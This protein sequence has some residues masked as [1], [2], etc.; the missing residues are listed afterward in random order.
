DHPNIARVLDAGAMDNG[1]PFFVMDLVLGLP[2]TDYCDKRKLGVEDRLELFS[3]VCQGIQHAHQKGIIH[4]DIKPSNVVVAVNNGQP[5]P[6]IIDFG[7]AKAMGAELTQQTYFTVA[8]QIVGTPQYMSPE[9]AESNAADIDTRSDIY[10]LG[11]LLYELLTGR[12]PIRKENFKGVGLEEMLRMIREH[13][14]ARP[15]TLLSRLDADTASSVTADRSTGKKRLAHSLKG[16]LDWLVMKALEKDRS[17]RYETANSLAADVRSFLR[18]EAITATPPTLRYRLG[19][20]TRRH[21]GPLFASS[22]IALALVGGLVASLWQADR[23]TK[24]AARARAAE[25]VALANLKIADEQRRIADEQRRIAVGEKEKANRARQFAESSLEKAEAASRREQ[26]ER[27]KAKQALD[28]KAEAQRREAEGE[29]RRSDLKNRVDELYSFLRSEDMRLDLQK[30]DVNGLE[31][32]RSI[33]QTI[34]RVFPIASREGDYQ[35]QDYRLSLKLGSTA[36]RSLESSLGTARAD[37][38][39]ALE[40]HENLRRSDNPPGVVELASIQME[41]GRIERMRGRYTEALAMLSGALNTLDPI[42]EEIDATILR[43]RILGEFSR[44]YGRLGDRKSAA[45][46]SRDAFQQAGL[47]PENSPDF[48]AGRLRSCSAL[49]EFAE[50]PSEEALAATR[51]HLALSRETKDP[52]LEEQLAADEARLLLEMRTLANPAFAG[53]DSPAG[54]DAAK[55]VDD[56]VSAATVA[57]LIKAAEDIR[58]RAGKSDGREFKLLAMKA[59]FMTAETLRKL[60]LTYDSLRHYQRCLDQSVALLRIDGEVAAPLEARFRAGVAMAKVYRDAKE[61]AKRVAALEN[62]YD[63]LL[64]ARRRGL[65]TTHYESGAPNFFPD[66]VE[67]AVYRFY[68]AMGSPSALEENALYADEVAFFQEKVDRR[69]ILKELQDYRVKYPRRIFSV[70]EIPEFTGSEDAGFRTRVVIDYWLADPT[71]ENTIKVDDPDGQLVQEIGFA[72]GD[73]N[74]L[75]IVSIDNADSKRAK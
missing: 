1:R 73:S 36:L 61:P 52:G 31:I 15:S 21:R 54:F 71:K 18:N 25:G 57:G 11:V 59:E 41:L 38:D 24:E 33:D 50:H 70:R 20:F 64:E 34:S 51:V 16:D 55:G 17:R 48:L 23:A 46:F 68:L 3:Q 12:T 44:L 28:Q 14:A 8:G 65:D 49:L 63:G 58:T 30:R 42:R 40:L 69:R 7:I 72:F 62:A 2:I 67:A 9:Q 29:V 13:E 39:S 37:Y 4:R 19:K 75:K 6:K 47:L 56:K 66:M 5:I 35:E 22:L 26:V 32:I 74:R 60:G 53:G 10:S 27:E 43:S 45:N